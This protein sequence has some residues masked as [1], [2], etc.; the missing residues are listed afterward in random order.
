MNG[1]FPYCETDSVMDK[2]KKV[3]FD[4]LW[5]YGSEDCGG[6]INDLLACYPEEVADALGNNPP[7]VFAALTDIW[8]RT[9]ANKPRRG[10]I[11]S[12]TM[13]VSSDMRSLIY[14]H[15]ESLYGHLLW[16]V[17]KIVLVYGE[18]KTIKVTE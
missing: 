12:K 2:L 13:K 8:E 7:E 16:T 4:T 3:A 15:T 18:N 14:G 11:I 1:E 9:R 10:V 5:R 6:W 17:K